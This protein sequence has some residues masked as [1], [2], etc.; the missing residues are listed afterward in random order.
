[1]QSLL[2]AILLA[3]RP[4]TP[5]ELLQ[6]RRP[7]DVRVSPDGHWASVTV[8]QKDLESNKDLKDIWLLPLHGGEGRQFTRN[9][10]SEHARWSPDGKQLLIVRE[11][12]LWLYPLEGG[13]GKQLTTLSTGADGGIFS[14]DGKTIAFTSEV[15]PQCD[16]RQG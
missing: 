6:T 11:G 12:Q 5:E 2:L 4:F 3:A 14:P 9:G 15:Y 13:E 16:T 8:R 1:M 7:D 10:K